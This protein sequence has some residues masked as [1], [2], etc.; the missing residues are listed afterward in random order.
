MVKFK[1]FFLIFILQFFVREASATFFPKL[2]FVK[3][4]GL[5]K[6]N[7]SYDLVV[8][9]QNNI[10]ITG[11][12]ANSMDLDPSS[13]NFII[14]G[15][16]D[17][18]DIF[19]AKY[20]SVGNFIWGFGMGS[21]YYDKGICITIDSV[22]DLLVA[23]YFTGTVDFDPN[24]QAGIISSNGKFDIF[25]AKYDSSGNLIW[26]NNIGEVGFSGSNYWTEPNDIIVKPDGT[27]FLSGTFEGGFDFDPGPSVTMAYSNLSKDAFLASYTTLGSFLWVRSFGGNFL[28]YINDMQLDGRGNIY[29]VGQFSNPIDFDGQ[30]GVYN[31]TASGIRDLFLMKY[32]EQGNF[33]WVKSIGGIY[34]DNANGLEIVGD[35]IYIT[36]TYRNTVDFDPGP[37]V[38]YRFTNWDSNDIFLC[39]FDTTGI[40]KWVY[41]VGGHGSDRGLDVIVDQCGFIVFVSAAESTTISFVINAQTYVFNSMWSLGLLLQVLDENGNLQ[42][43]YEATSPGDTYINALKFNKRNNSIYLTGSFSGNI[44]FDFDSISSTATSCIGQSN[45]FFSKYNYCDSILP[46]PVIVEEEIPIGIYPNPFV[47]E[48]TISSTELMEEV[49][50]YSSEGK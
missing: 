38:A 3:T 35:K 48:L 45:I 2:D 10:Y 34:D 20:D 14:S 18:A 31:L 32:D 41:T 23:G 40:F 29:A 7:G 42:S 16:G 25:F 47:N 24:S 26:I 19:L 11:L 1:I 46:E 30:A 50:L 44:D 15:S 36:G 22:G 28:N 39:Q 49:L 9:N 21:I 8:D 5:I 43:V 6:K 27:I 4:L 13:S 37:G 12:Y 33:H 17:S